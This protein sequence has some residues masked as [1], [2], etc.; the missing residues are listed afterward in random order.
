MSYFNCDKCGY[1]W[2]DSHTYT[3]CPRCTEFDKPDLRCKCVHY[4]TLAGT[5]NLIAC[6]NPNCPIHGM[7]KISLMILFIK[8]TEK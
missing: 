4:A 6:K 8:L 2:S 1:T 3:S 7:N 5:L